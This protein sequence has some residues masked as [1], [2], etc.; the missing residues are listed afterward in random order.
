MLKDEL[1]KLVEEYKANKSIR[2]D[3]V[4]QEIT[5]MLKENALRGETEVEFYMTD[6]CSTELHS[7]IIKK[8]KDDGLSVQQSDYLNWYIVSWS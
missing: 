2:L 4:Y 7:D 8:L 1:Q 5:L 6:Y 3:A